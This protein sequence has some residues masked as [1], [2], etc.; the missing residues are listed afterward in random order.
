MPLG[1]WHGSLVMLGRASPG[2]VSAPTQAARPLASLAALRK[3]GSSILPRSTRRTLKTA[4]VGWARRIG[5][6][7]HPT[8]GP[9]ILAQS[10][11]GA[12]GLGGADPGKRLRPGRFPQLSSMGS[13]LNNRSSP[14]PTLYNHMASC[15]GGRH[16]R[17]PG[18]QGLRTP[19]SQLSS[20][21]CGDLDRQEKVRG[22]KPILYRLSEGWG[23]FL[24]DPKSEVLGPK[25]QDDQVAPTKPPGSQDT[26][27]H[28][29]DQ[30]RGALGGRGAWTPAY[31]HPPLSSLFSGLWLGV[32]FRCAVAEIPCHCV[33]RLNNGPGPLTTSLRR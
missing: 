31:S 1:S 19:W 32:W 6:P 8:R 29:R 5:G 22:A 24:A 13:H 21:V 33:P 14:N 10:H 27:P 9:G 17:C 23:P 20:E 11:S 26:S 7:E 30:G 28:F 12:M 18:D 15:C 25:A 16:C 2:S 3:V 4:R